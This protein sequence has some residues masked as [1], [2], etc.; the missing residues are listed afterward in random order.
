MIVGIPTEI[1]PQEHR[2]GAVPALVHDLVAGGHEVVVQS[3]AGLG[4][5]LDDDAYRDAGAR[6]VAEAAA[7]YVDADLIVKVKE[8][9]ADEYPLIRPGQS[10]FTY[11]HF[12]ASRALTDAMLASGAHCFAYETLTVGNERPLLA[13]MS[14]IAGRMAAQVGACHLAAHHG[15]RGVLMGGVP[16]VAPARVLVLGGGNVGANAARMAAGLGADVT[17]LDIDL[18]RLRRLDAVMPANVRT[19]ASSD[20]ALREHLPSVDLIIGAV[21]VNGARAP[22]LI[23]RADLALMHDDGPVIV[24]VAVDQGGC[25][26]TSRPTTHADPTFTVDGVLHYCVAN[27]PGAFPRTATFALT[28]ATAPY[29][30]RLADLG[31]QAAASD[32]ILAS[33]ANILDGNVTQPAV[34]EAFDLDYRPPTEVAC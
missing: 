14:E 22:V 7:V 11:F 29:I 10:L 21:L 13:P 2:V 32:P 25:V 27:M 31:P 5:G 19:L 16:G 18:E 33:A 24:D 34:A 6:I 30:R 9:L 12:A 17:I 15:G 23:R 8:P 3:G 1:K 26:E 28:N 4:A 20:Y